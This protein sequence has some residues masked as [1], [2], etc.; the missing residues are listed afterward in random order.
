[1]PTKKE[2][3]KQ[4]IQTVK[5]MGVF[6]I[7]NIANGKIFIGSGMNIQGK[8]NSCQFQLSHGSHVNKAMQ[9]DYKIFGKD[10]FSFE[11]IDYLEPKEDQKP[12]SVDDL[13][14]LEEMWIE[15]L[16]PYDEK[17]YHNRKIQE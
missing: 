15:R 17:G 12:D 8:M 13:K 5:P 11:I 9:A 4:Y 10:N 3:K 14:V 7:T 6:K 16:Q 1:M 2:L